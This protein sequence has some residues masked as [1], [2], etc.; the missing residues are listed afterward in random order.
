[1]TRR[2]QHEIQTKAD[3]PYDRIC[4]KCQ[5]IWHISDYMDWTAK[6]MMTLPVGIRFAVLSVQAE[7]FANEF[8]K[9]HPEHYHEGGIY[10]ETIY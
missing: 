2:C 10:G 6:Q 7:K 4:Q 5:T 8:L 9:E 3:Y 1:M